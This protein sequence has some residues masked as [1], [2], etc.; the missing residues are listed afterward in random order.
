MRIAIFGLGAVGG[1]LGARLAA[2]GH[3]VCVIARGPTLDAIRRNG[4]ELRSGEQIIKV[5]VR[6]SDRPAD[7]DEPDMVI[8]TVKATEPQALAAG[9]ASIMRRGTAV[10]FA[11]NGVPWWYELGRTKSKQPLPDL[12]FLDPG[13]ALQE[14]IPADQVIG[15]VIHSSNE[16]VEPGV[17][18]NASPESNTLLV[19]EVDNRASARIAELRQFLESAG[20]KSP[21]VSDIRQAIWRKLMI[22][23]S[24]SVICLLTGQK[25]SVIRDDR[26]IGALYLALAREAIAVARAHGIDTRGFDPE[27]FRANAPDHLPSIRQDYERGRALEI[28]SMLVAPQAFARAAGVDTPHFDTVVTLAVRMAADRGLYQ[29]AEVAES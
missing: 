24:A 12:E 25:A 1:H 19:G 21:E 6:A 29:P 7:F 11:Q 16:M 13:R 27:A 22:N 10:V 15:A 20:I 2:S 18:Y 4:L 9:L 8:V 5:E 3:D 17:V 14:L 26:R 23:M 28:D